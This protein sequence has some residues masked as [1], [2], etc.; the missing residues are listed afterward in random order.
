MST[1]TVD[2]DALAQQY[3]GDSAPASGQNVDYDALAKQYGAISSETPGQVTNDVGE[4]IIVPKDGE[5]YQDTIRRAIARGKTVQQ[6]DID[7]EMAT[8]PRKV[9]AVLTAAPVVG[10]AGAA[11]IAASDMGLYQAAKGLGYAGEAVKDALATP[12]GKT[13][14]H[15]AV[16][17]GLGVAGWGIVYTL[18]KKAGMFSK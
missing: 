9:A 6:S 11:G 18:A 14:L 2:Y 3:G 7:K 13:L 10:A 5:S 16:K 17:R 8:A 1:P 15:E 4:Q 12:M